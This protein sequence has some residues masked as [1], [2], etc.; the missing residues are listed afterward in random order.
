MLQH[1]LFLDFVLV[2]HGNWFLSKG[3]L[4]DFYP[5]HD[6]FRFVELVTFA[7][8]FQSRQSPK[9]NIAQ[10]VT[11]WLDILKSD[12]CR[13]IRI[14]WISSTNP[15]L[16]DRMTVGLVGGGGRRLIETIFSPHCDLWES[17]WDIGDRNHPEKKIWNVRYSRI[18]RNSRPMRFREYSIQKES[19]S[20][21][22][23]LNRAARLSDKPNLEFWHKAFLRGLQNLD[24][25]HEPD[26]E[27]IAM[28]NQ[29]PLSESKLLAAAQNSWVFG[30][31][32]SWND[33]GFDGQDQKEYESISNELFRLLCESLINVVNRTCSKQDESWWKF[34]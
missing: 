10:N 17:H 22:L 5:N 7:S 20:L 30:G 2:T 13:G 34:W 9:S 6:A 12:G 25:A 4:A 26:L 31:M 29:L 23:I 8:A 24:S 27:G 33:L 11:E 15:L 32:G 14:H 21:K 28:K 19:Q 18:Q 16:S 1:T 3:T